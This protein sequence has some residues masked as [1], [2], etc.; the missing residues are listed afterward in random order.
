MRLWFDCFVRVTEFDYHLPPEY[1]ATQPLKDR[2]Q[3]RLMLLHRHSGHISHHLFSELPDLL[4]STDVLV[5]NNT[6]VFPAR[7]LGYR[8]G[9]TSENRGIGGVL[10]ARIEVLLVKQVERDVWD[11]LVKPGRKIRI[12]EEIHFGTGELRCSVLGRGPRGLRR[13]RF[14]YQ[15]KFEDLVDKLG[16]VPL[17]PYI[18]RPD[19]AEDRNRYQTVFAKKRGAVAAPTAGLH[20]TRKILDQLQK[21]GV[22]IQEITLHVGPGTF[23]PVRSEIV[24][25]HQMEAENFEVSSEAACAIQQARTKGK[26]II[27]V[28]TTVARTLESVAARNAGCIVPDAGE[29]TLFIFPGYSFSAVDGL[30]TN[31]HLPRSTLLML[32]SAFAG[33]DLMR[34]AYK[35]AIAL[36]YRFYSYGDCMLIL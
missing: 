22:Q 26:R 4:Q 2:D 31:F 23:Q 8:L 35:Q 7:L 11:A 36:E 16:H 14:D 24:E 1:I 17:P 13:L 30:L 9:L 20:F 27:A 33:L 10:H 29:T 34:E 18:A 12:G 5:L 32:V 3:S 15:G 25:E 21:K 6:L 19:T 28:G